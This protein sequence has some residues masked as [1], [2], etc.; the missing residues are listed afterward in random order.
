MLRFRQGIVVQQFSNRLE[1]GVKRE[2][3]RNI[4]PVCREQFFLEQMLFRSGGAK[5][6]YLHFFPK[7]GLPAEYLDTL[8]QTLEDLAQ[9]AEPDTFFLPTETSLVA[10]EDTGSELKLLAQK[11]RGFALPRRSE[12]IGNTITLSVCPGVD[13]TSDGERLLSCAE[14]G[15]RMSKLLGLRCLV[16]E[17]PIPPLGAQQFGDF[18]IDTLP[19]ALQSFFGNRD[20]RQDQADQLLERYAA[21]RTVDRE[22]RTG[23]DSVAWDLTRALGVTPLEIFA[24]AGRALERK[25][26][27]GKAT[28]PEVLANRIRARLVNT[29]EI[30]VNGGTAMADG[31]SVS[32]RLKING[33]TC[34][35]TY[36]T[37][38]QFQTEFVA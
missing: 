24:V 31:D 6:M 9:K 12:A 18:Y 38:K 13:V 34:S 16:S 17:A 30:L 20:L 7:S 26:S 22:V 37:R 4:C 3:K 35:R 33:P 19:S 5:G 27:G 2:P 36:H 15:L 21:L 14:I 8:R 11:A 32:A 1:G 28:A 25:M 10:E 23:Y 29:L